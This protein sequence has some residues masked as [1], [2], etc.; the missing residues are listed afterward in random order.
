MN[1]FEAMQ[2]FCVL[3]ADPDAAFCQALPDSLTTL[4]VVDLGPDGLL[5]RDNAGQIRTFLLPPTACLGLF[6]SRVARPLLERVRTWMIERGGDPA[7]DVVLADGADETARVTQAVLGRLLAL[8]LS[9]ARAAAEHA[10]QVASLRV[11]IEAMAAAR[12][13]VDRFLGET[14]LAQMTCVFSTREPDYETQIELTPGSPLRQLLPIPS[15][16]FA[17][18]ELACA[19]APKRRSNL[20]AR[21]MSVE[22]C[23]VLAEWQ[24]PPPARDGWVRLG[25]PRAGAGVTRT[26]ALVVEPG[27]ARTPCANLALGGHQPLGSAQLTDIETGES[28]APHS[29]AFRAYAALPDTTPPHADGTLLPVAAERP[30]QTPFALRALPHETLVRL[31]PEAVSNEVRKADDEPLVLFV[32]EAG[33][34]L[35]RPGFGGRLPDALRPEAQGIALDLSVHAD[36]PRALTVRLRIGEAGEGRAPTSLASETLTVGGSSAQTLSLLLPAPLPAP[37][38]LHF[39]VDAVGPEAGGSAW[40]VLSRLRIYQ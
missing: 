30:R 12:A 35:C 26:L 28:I 18:I 29:L 15:T 33:A 9:L 13:D 37:A 19:A 6:G 3:I 4:E 34:I 32:P 36:V 20:I 8:S 10:Q 11:E 22:D 40:A 31:A 24:I 1:R 39:S 5:C 38:D 7:P 14:G 16:G 23:E 17:A 2:G 21:L 25:L 27:S